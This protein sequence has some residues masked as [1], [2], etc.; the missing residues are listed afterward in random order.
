MPGYDACLVEAELRAR[1]AY[2]EPHRHYHDERHLDDCLRQLDR[3]LDLPEWDQRLLRWAILWHD[4]IY[5]PARSDNEER[6]AELAFRELT[7]CTVDE[8]TAGEVARLILLTSGHEVEKGDRLGALLVSI[9]L[10]ILGSDGDRYGEYVADVRREYGH[11]TEAAWRAGRAAVLK[12]LLASNPLYPDQRF[13][14]AFEAQA[15]RNM[16]G[17]FKALGAIA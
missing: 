15:R 11:V 10:S 14:A 2:A 3:L 13:R 1:A 8:T 5:D 4:A 17:E 16:A 7:A 6:S 12:R 9:D